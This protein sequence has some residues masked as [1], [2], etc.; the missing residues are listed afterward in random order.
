MGG[1]A[2][3][4]LE[5]GQRGGGEVKVKSDCGNSGGL[6]ML[7]EHSILELNLLYEVHSLCTINIHQYKSKSEKEYLVH[8]RYLNNIRKIDLKIHE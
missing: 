2:E 4:V 1:S 8:S 3:R 6:D 7:K 5:E